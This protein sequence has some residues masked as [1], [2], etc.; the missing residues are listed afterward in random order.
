[1]TRTLHLAASLALLTLAVS[2]C[3]RQQPAT[4]VPPSPTIELF[5]VSDAEVSA[6]E[7]VTLRWKVTD[8]T[9]LELREATLG[10][11]AV[12]A[13]QFEGS[14]DV[15]PTTTSLYVLTVRGESGSDA[16]A[17]AVTV[18]PAAGAVSFQALPP[19]IPGGD[20]TTLVWLAPGARTVTLAAG[21]T[22][23]DTAGQLTSGAVTVRPLEDTT[24]TLTVDGTAHSLQVVVQPAVLR[25]GATTSTVAPGQTVELTWE[26]AGVTRLR[27]SRAG[28]GVLLDTTTA[29]TIASGRFTEVA[30]PLPEGAVLSYELDVEKGSTHVTRAV[31]VFI[32][33]GP[34]IER[35]DA[36][37][38]ALLN[39]TY[40]MRWTTSGADE[41]QVHLN[42]AVTY[43]TSNPA[44]TALGA[45]VIPTPTTDFQVELVATTTRGGSAR[46]SVAVD[47]VGVPTT[48]TLGAAPLTVAEGQPV[49]L[50]WNSLDA[51]RL[52]IVDS[53]TQPVFS[54]TGQMAQ[55]GSAQVYP[56]G[57]SETYTITVDN[58]LGSAPVTATA[59]V[60]VTGPALDVTQSPKTAVL[61]NSFRTVASDP[62]A[63][64]LGFPHSLILTGTSADFVDIK[65]T[66]QPLDIPNTP[67]VTS[68]ETGF[69]T[70]LWGEK[71]SSS[72]T[73]CRAGWMAFGAPVTLDATEVA[74]PSSGAPRFVLAPFWDDLRASTDTGFFWQVVGDAPNERLIVQ[75]DRLQ[76]GTD[77]DTE[78]TFQVQVHQTGLV[79]FQYKTMV[80]PSAVT[81]TI[82]VQDGTNTRAVSTSVIPDSDTALYF[83][84]PVVGS[85]ETQAQRGARWG[86]F[87][88]KGG[89][90]ALVTRRTSAVTMP[91]DV[92]V[93]EVMFNP[94]STVAAGQYAEFLNRTEEPLDLSGWVLGSPNGTSF[95]LPQ[96]FTL[97]PDTAVVL[98]AS[99][100]AV[101][102]DDAGV[103]VAWGA[104]TLPSDGGALSLGIGDAGFSLPF[105]LDAGAGTAVVVDPGLFR[106]GATTTS[107]FLVCNAATPFGEQ[108]PQQ[109]GTPGQHSGCGFG[110]RSRAITPHFVDITDGGTPLVNSPAV[111]I[112]NLTVPITLAPSPGDPQPLLFGVPMPVV[113]M[114]LDGFLAPYSTTAVNASNKTNPG[115][116]V[117][118]RAL[119]APFWDDLQTTLGLTP[120]SDL[121]WKRMAANEDPL[122]PEPH[123]IFQWHRLRHTGTSPADDLSFEVKLFEDG[124]VEYHYGAMVSGTSTNY[125]NGNSAT[126]WLE[127]P[128][129]GAALT[130]SVN[131]ASVVPFSAIRFIPQ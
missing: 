98:G 83:F 42:G 17:V 65:S 57:P 127:S 56:H 105:A 36:P 41:V 2:G 112:T 81:F 106:V 129:A 27:L 59:T 73:V 94:A 74:L 107:R 87:V 79:S 92:A 122:R 108:A 32:G 63:L 95:T 113:S 40:I 7:P 28:Q 70:W 13:D 99:T 18:P 53:D 11:L 26:T 120:A 71:Q 93:T 89:V 130:V 39:G 110:Y 82:G 96:G 50:T 47:V 102:N 117:V 1:M 46:R 103:S 21:A 97:Q 14:L 61:G 77:A 64:L 115:N 55:S 43:S 48:V 35:F 76:V 75:W 121:Y 62:Q 131:T 9:G 111:V 8:A 44:L 109:L 31:E 30:P 78:V 58:G 22:A 72:L 37:T 90:R 60:S 29:A 101:A 4:V 6:G 119:L 68:F 25:F 66:G 49:T 116:G 100:D 5:T 19:T 3:K 52:R 34:V 33:T 84:S 118:P 88:Q 86:G 10:T 124:V 23:V 128:D 69:T 80:L 51:R 104:L 20:L 16:R 125:A 85:A 91:D 15:T 114:S 24:F 38:V 123:W 67:G 54:T 12:P 45:L 126:V